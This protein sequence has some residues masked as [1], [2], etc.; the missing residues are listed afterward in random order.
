M[1][2][3]LNGLHTWLNQLRT[4]KVPLVLQYEMVE[5]GAASLSMILRFYGR[6]LPLHIL[7]DACGVSRDG[8][9][10]L[11][12]KNAGAFFGLE[13]KAAR[14][15]AEQLMTSQGCFPCIA[16]WDYNH[17][18]VLQGH[19]G[20]RLLVVDPALGRYSLHLN[21]VQK[22]FSGLILF[23]KPGEGFSVEGKPENYVADLVPILRRYSRQLL[24][25]APISVALIVP[26]LLQPGISGAFI[27][28]VL[29][30]SRFQYAF[31]ILWLSVLALILSVGLTLARLRILRTI[32][33]QMS[34][35]L[36]TQLATKLLSVNYLFYSS[37][38]LGD[39]TSRLDI[40]DHVSDVLALQL[41][42]FLFGLITAI[43]LIPAV[44]LISPFLAGASL[45]YV[46]INIMLAFLSISFVLDQ[47]KL[48][49]LV[50]GKV[51][52]L[53][54]RIF[55]DAKTIKSSALENQY[56]TQWQ[57]LYQP[58]FDQN[59]YIQFTLNT[60]S[61]LENL[62]G[63]VY[64]YG[65]IA[66]S[67]YLVIVGELNLAGFMA[68][69]VIR[70]QVT[71]P[72]IAVSGI[73]HAM[74]DLNAELGRLNDLSTVADDPKVQSLQVID[75]TK[76]KNAVLPETSVD[77]QANNVAVQFSAIKPP[78][79]QQIT[80]SFRAGSMN[81]I[82]GPSGSGKSVFLKTLT[83]FYQPSE[84]T[85]T[86]D[87]KPW[88]EYSDPVIRSAVGYVCQEVTALRG[89]VME[90]I[91]LHD[92][93]ITEDQVINA[94]ETA[95]LMDVID[96]LPLGLH[97]KLG[98]SGAGLSGGQLQ[99]LQIARALVRQPK[100]L[101][102]DEAT[103][104]LDIPT[105][106]QLLTNLKAM[107]ITLVCVAHRLISAQMSDHLVVLKDGQLL[108]SGAP[109]VLSAASDSFYA[110]LLKADSAQQGGD[111]A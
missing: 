70:E 4:K 101:F 39:I 27:S 79:I 19:Q 33:L 111:N 82:V 58:Q 1:K 55:S 90:N 16:W 13:A 40:A 106:T 21:E 52:G 72:L 96:K 26:A 18:V 87:G 50:Q 31:P 45:L 59:Q 104:A 102:L 15:T 91:T 11:D 73:S 42:P 28:E 9:N 57:K 64:Q 67:G 5:C 60:F 2:N 95:V 89:S 71:Q 76:Q 22:H 86:Y 63:S 36:F 17:F 88:G 48:V 110:Q 44:W 61:S 43:F 103:S 14:L 12:I 35:I 6:Y 69:Q 80:A 51:S 75:P 81:T 3:P 100:I 46:L 107:G 98:N 37:R 65:T 24:L 23:F 108:E 85:I 56:L 66:L 53:T 29:T 109:A 74:Q 38:Y 94:C 97:T 47:T 41:A 54:L 93:Y 83:G 68:F 77:V 7:R 78:L 105:E 8:S 30:N 10:L 34:R 84:G 32:Y 99:R 92:P 49:K 20:N 25:I 62:S